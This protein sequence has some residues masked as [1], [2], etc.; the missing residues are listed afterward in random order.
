[1]PAPAHRLQGIDHGI[2]VHPARREGNDRQRVEIDA[3]VFRAIHPSGLLRPAG[4]CLAAVAQL[5]EHHQVQFATVITGV[6]VATHAAGDLQLDLGIA[7]VE[8]SQLLGGAAGS[9]VVRHA[10]THRQHHRGPGQRLEH[11]IVQCQ[12]APGISQQGLAGIG[13]QHIAIAAL[14]QA[15][16]DHLLQAADLLADGGL[17]GMQASGGRGE[18][19]A[20]GHRDNG[21]QQVEVEQAAIGFLNVAHAGICFLNALRLSTGSGPRTQLPPRR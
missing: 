19:A 9:E 20:V 17:G 13:G 5:L 6:E 7:P 18:T 21:P 2:A 11:F 16:P 1:M 12:Q 8:R 4:Q 14:K 15:L 10:D 3:G